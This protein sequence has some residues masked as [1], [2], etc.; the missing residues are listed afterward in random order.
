MIGRSL[1]VLATALAFSASAAAQA[2]SYDGTYFVHGFNDGYYRFDM[3]VPALRARGLDLKAVRAPSLSSTQPVAIQ[4]DELR[5]YQNGYLWFSDS[6]ILV[7]HSMG[8]LTS[9]AAYLA[10]PANIVGIVTVATPH[11][12]S[13]IAVGGQR[14]TRHMGLVVARTV[15]AIVGFATYLPFSGPTVRHILSDHGTISDLVVAE[16][17]TRNAASSPGAADLRPASATIQSLSAARADGVLPRANV[18]G[19]IPYRHAVW[20]VLASAQRNEGLASGYIRTRTTVKSFAK[21]CK[22]VAYATIILWAQG[23]ECA[24]LDRAISQIDNE[25]LGA[26]NGRAPSGR[27]LI[28]ANDGLVPQSHSIYPSAA[29][30]QPRIAVGANH[31]NITYVLPGI[32]ALDAALMSVGVKRSP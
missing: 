9:R 15:R 28:G 14:F 30:L 10:N 3:T 31:N 6:T 25:Y 2:A 4:A 20:Y 27:P 26:V 22:H 7:G 13:P 11:Q 5:S 29:S 21:T 32:V 24:K 23:R 16:I 18:V 8:G 12:G 1:A 19:E 17:N